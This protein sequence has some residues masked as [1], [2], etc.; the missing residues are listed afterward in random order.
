MNAAAKGD[1]GARLS[2]G[3]RDEVGDLFL[4]FNRLADSV[5]SRLESAEVMLPT[6]AIA[7]AGP[8][9]FA[10]DATVVGTALPVEPHQTNRPP[11]AQRLRL[12]AGR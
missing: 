10:A 3:R 6:S 4:V 2:G 7:D 1:L 12:A 5:Q 9:A 8:I 11:F